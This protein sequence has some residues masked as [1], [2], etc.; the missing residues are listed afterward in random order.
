M[1][2]P[3]FDG[4]LVW[5]STSEAYGTPSSDACLRKRVTVDSPLIVAAQA[6]AQLPQGDAEAYAVTAAD[7]AVDNDGGERSFVKAGVV[8]QLG[9]NLFVNFD[10]RRAQ[11]V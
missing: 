3:G 4:W 7:V 9:I 11:M 10:I 5:L 8:L 1:Q 6:F 2:P